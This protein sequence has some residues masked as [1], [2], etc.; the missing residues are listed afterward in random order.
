[1]S[2][3]ILEKNLKRLE[4]NAQLMVSDAAHAQNTMEDIAVAAESALD[5]DE[6][7][8]KHVDALREILRM[9]RGPGAVDA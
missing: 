9:I 1:M 8:H 2:G 3:Q 4:R 5:Y 6:P 7:S